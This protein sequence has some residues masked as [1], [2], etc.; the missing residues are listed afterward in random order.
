MC[1]N[2]SSIEQWYDRP[3]F[4]RQSWSIRM[5]NENGEMLVCLLFCVEKED[6]RV[7]HVI[8]TLIWI[9]LSIL[10]IAIARFLTSLIDVIHFNYQSR[11]NLSIDT[12]RFNRFWSSRRNHW[13]ELLLSE[14]QQEQR[15]G[16][17]L[18]K[19]KE[20]DTNKKKSEWD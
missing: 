16:G 17:F 4:V 7:V 13:C 18:I 2:L 9:P 5:I 3:R 12:T 19:R 6:Q 14:H 8:F 11:F 20:S 15:K 10:P 1:R